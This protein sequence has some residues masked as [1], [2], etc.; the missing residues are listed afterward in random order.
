MLFRSSPLQ[1]IV[2]KC[3]PQYAPYWISLNG[4]TLSFYASSTNSS[5]NIANNVGFGTVNLNTWNH[6][7]IS[8]S[9]TNIYCFTNGVLGATVSV[10]A[11]ALTD[12]SSPFTIGSQYNGN[13]LFN[14]YISN[15]RLTL[16][17]ALYT[18]NFTPSS[19]PFTTTSQGATASDVSL[20]TLQSNQPN[21]N[22]IFVDNSTNNFLIT[23]NGNTTQG[24]RKST[25]LNSSH[26][27]LSRMPSSA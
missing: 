1:V 10:G 18:T 17:T 11:N 9:T 2:A 13:N 19:S 22:N 15:I 4:Y 14:G 3:S 26:I 8:R 24:D 16:N 23:R 21:T 5:W 6:F 25:R 27:P 7:A 12:H 20:L